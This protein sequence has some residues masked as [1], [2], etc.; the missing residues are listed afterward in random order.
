[1]R[2]TSLVVCLA[3]CAPGLLA[4][5]PTD[6]GGPVSD[7]AGG[8]GA[9]AAQSNVAA[10]GGAAGKSLFGG[11]VSALASSPV[12]DFFTRLWGD[13]ELISINGWHPI[14]DSVP[15]PYQTPVS[16][17]LWRGSRI[18]SPAGYQD[19]VSRG[20]KSIVDL[21]A[22]GTLDETEAAKAGLTLKRVPI[23]DDH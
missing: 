19:L 5:C 12:G 23:I 4:D 8:V 18:D 6:A 1:M 13:A 10:A 17:C 2:V 11:I 3:L 16:A 22:E 7:L 9:A 15:N 20:F 21:T 14:K